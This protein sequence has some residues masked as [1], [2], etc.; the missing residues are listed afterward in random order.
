MLVLLSVAVGRTAGARVA[1]PIQ[2]NIIVVMTDDQPPGMMRALPAVQRLI[3]D[4]GATFENAFA[5]YPICCPARATFLT[6]QHA[7]NHGTLGNGPLTGGGYPALI[8]PKRNLAAWLQRAG[9]ETAFAGKWLNGLRTPRAAP[10]GWDRWNGLVGAGGES[11]SSFYE[12]DIFQGNGVPPRHYGS[13][14]RDY[15]TDVLLRDYALPLIAT[16]VATP[17]PFFL[18]LAVHPPH[19]GVG[20]D[21]H[22]GRRCTV[23]QPDDRSGKQSAIPAPRHASRFARSPI[24]HPPSFD[25]RDLRDKPKFMRDH[26]PLSADDRELIRLNY[27]CGLAALLAVDEAVRSIVIALQQSGQ[28]SSTVLVFTTDHGALG[29][30]H[31]IK[32][33]KNRPY[34]EAIRVPLLVSGPMIPAGVTPSGPVPNT[35]LA[36]TLLELALTGVPP[37]LARPFDGVS[38]VSALRSGVSERRRVVLIEGRDKVARSRHGFK[39]RSYVG[40]RTERYAYTEHRRASAPNAG[41]AIGLPIGAGRKTD[42][43]LY[44]LDRDPYE[45][46]SRHRDRA[47]TATR[48]VLADLTKRLERCSG[49]QCVIA[50]P[51]PGPQ[52]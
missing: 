28:L 26:P 41:A 46:E 24:P 4:R 3:G 7:H 23:G 21:D 5:S 18:W 43:E 20:R 52:R 44:D 40:V 19:D 27:R 6:G 11:L 8:D 25:E 48:R 15:Q 9:Y 32:A 51:V 31:R 38:Q 39:A 14:S 47:Y 29:G 49:A 35:D 37:D 33:G 12:Y 13:A 30:E 17:E 22:A 16:Q 45:L 36:P 34:E 10:P 50:A 1:T 2:P 42:V